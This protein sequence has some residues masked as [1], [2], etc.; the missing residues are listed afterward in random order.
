V[1][2]DLSD[3]LVICLAPCDEAALAF[4]LPGHDLSRQL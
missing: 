3:H 1:A 4:D 2:L